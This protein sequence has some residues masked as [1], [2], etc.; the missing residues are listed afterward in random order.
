MIFIVRASFFPLWETPSS[1]G[2][3]ATANKINNVCV[4]VSCGC[5]VHDDDAKLAKKMETS[6]FLLENITFV[7]FFLRKRIFICIFANR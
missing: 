5:L 4:V 3:G 1:V 7:T 6:N 2:E